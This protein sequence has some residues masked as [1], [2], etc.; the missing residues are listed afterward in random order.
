[1]S[2]DSLNDLIDKDQLR[3]LKQKMKAL[4]IDDKCIKAG[5]VEELDFIST[6]VFE[7]DSLLGAG[8]GIPSGTLIEFCGESQSGKTW[9]G[10]KLIGQ[11]QK[12]GKKCAFF[13][14]ENSYY[15]QRAMSCGVNI[16][17]LVLVENVGSAEKYGELLKY[18]VQT[19]EYAIIVV[20]SVSAMI[21]QDELTKTLEQVQSIGL[22][23]RFVKRLT[24]DLTAKTSETGTIVVLI[25]QL[26]MGAGVMPG[27]FTK[28]AS[29]GNAMNYFTHMRLWINKIN[30]ANGQV[31]KKDAEGK[32]V[33]IGGK[34]KVLVMKT[35][36]GT[37]G[38]TGEFKIMFTDDETTNPL[39]EFLYRAKAKGFE[40]IKEL[41]KKFIY[42]NGDTG[43]QIESKDSYEFVNLLI[44]HPAPLKRTRGDESK[45]VFEYITGR[46]KITGKPLEDLLAFIKKGPPSDSE[47]I[48]DPFDEEEDDGISFEEAAKE[49]L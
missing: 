16:N 40:F 27:T 41:R 6:G 33:I 20:D 35:R 8:M 28:T 23:A 32:D 14:V 18:M 13:N 17:Q 7:V 12:I 11:A 38:L 21:P 2:K 29:G 46:L 36:Y 22:H 31:T 1:M 39:D 3:L 9:L 44:S 19:G 42:I 10:Y 43:E 26:Y 5:D 45:T 34:S 48:S 37:P 47:D 25:N 49:M 30:G 4:G 15:P 24:K